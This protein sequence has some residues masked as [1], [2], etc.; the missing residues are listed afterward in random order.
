MSDWKAERHSNGQTWGV[1]DADDAPVVWE[2]GGCDEA[3]ARQIAQEHNE[4]VKLKAEGPDLEVREAHCL[5]CDYFETYHPGTPVEEVRMRMAAHDH[6]CAKNPITERARKAEARLDE[7]DADKNT[8]ECPYS[9]ERLGCAVLHQ[10]KARVTELTG[11][12]DVGSKGTGAGHDFARFSNDIRDLALYGH[13]PRGRCD[14]KTCRHWMTCTVSKSC[15]RGR[16]REITVP[17]VETVIHEGSGDITLRCRSFE[18]RS[19][20]GSAS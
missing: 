8:G 14:A 15:Q 17:T 4:L 11:V 7:F 5:Y 3:T 1:Y 20:G 10:F 9:R 16:G 18:A 2:M 13:D 19:K 6:E 12:V